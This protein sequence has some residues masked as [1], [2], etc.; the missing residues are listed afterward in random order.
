M[1]I[2]KSPYLLIPAVTVGLLTA[3][4]SPDPNEPVD[5]EAP[6]TARLQPFETAL[7]FPI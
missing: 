5:P 4:G 2:L 7:D 3:C 6:E 1:Q